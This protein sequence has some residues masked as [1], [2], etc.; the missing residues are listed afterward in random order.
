MKFSDQEQITL[1][2]LPK[3]SSALSITGSSFLVIKLWGEPYKTK[4]CKRAIWTMSAFDILCSSAW[5]LTTWPMEKGTV[6]VKFAVGNKHTCTIQGFFIQLGIAVPIL[7][8]LL[9][10]Y[11]LAIIRFGTSE[12]KLN[13][14][15]PWIRGFVLLFP[16]VAALVCLALGK[17]NDARLWCWIGSS[18]DKVFQWVLYFGPLWIC[19]LL[20]MIVFWVIYSYVYR[21]E[22]KSNRFAASS[23]EYAKETARYALLYMVSFFVTWIPKSAFI[24]WWTSFSNGNIKTEPPFGLVLAAAFCSPLQGFLNFLIYEQKTGDKFASFCCNANYYDKV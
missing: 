9:S 1:A 22:E 18:Q 2:I 5:F 10:F 20:Q 7:N 19:F 14:R 4:S 11:Y 21:V 12:K 6:G 15:D 24:I 8:V 17:F 23:H 3:I 13:D 16:E